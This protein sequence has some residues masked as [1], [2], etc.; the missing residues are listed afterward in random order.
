[1]G[2]E[3]RIETGKQEVGSLKGLEMQKENKEISKTR[4]QKKEPKGVVRLK[5]L[6]LSYFFHLYVVPSIL[7][8]FL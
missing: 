7:H 1:M 8:F 5:K 4:V 3:K 6:T 2:E